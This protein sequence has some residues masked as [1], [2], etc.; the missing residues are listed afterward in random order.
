MDHLGRVK[1]T[2][3]SIS[4]YLDEPGKNLN[5]NQVRAYCPNTY[6]V[7]PGPLAFVSKTDSFVTVSSSYQLESYK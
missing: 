4:A 3:H 6:T 1:C 2:I 5:G 7:L